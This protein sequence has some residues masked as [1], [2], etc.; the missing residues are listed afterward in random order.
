MLPLTACALPCSICRRCLQ[1]T[2][3]RACLS[4]WCNQ[5]L[6]LLVL[7]PLPG[8]PCQIHGSKG[9]KIADQAKLRLLQLQ[10]RSCSILGD[11]N[12]NFN[13]V[14][15]KTYITVMNSGCPETYQP[16]EKHSFNSV[17]LLWV[18]FCYFH[19]HLIHASLYHWLES[20]RKKKGE[21][22]ET[23]LSL[24]REESKVKCEN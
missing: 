19:A 2:M 1:N 18:K 20:L 6:S 22:I 5:A 23:V 9:T 3:V 24:S 14:F 16:F 7:I 8:M 11:Y 12:S 15:K 10:V 13:Y 17:S 21:L 4:I